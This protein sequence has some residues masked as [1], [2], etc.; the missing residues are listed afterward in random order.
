MGT[1]KINFLILFVTLLIFNLQ[2][3]SALV[4]SSDSYS[5]NL[6]GEGLT[7]AYNVSSPTYEAQTVSLPSSG[8]RGTESLNYTVNIGYFENTSYFKSV[9]IS[10]YS[11]S[12][13][14]T[15]VGSTV[16]LSILA[17]NPQSVWAKITSP[18]GQDQILTLINNRSVNYLPSPSVVGDYEVTFY[19][20]NSMGSVA[21]I[22]DHFELTS[23]PVLETS[24]P[25]SSGGPST[26]IEKCNY[27]W[28][29]TSWGLCSEGKQKRQCKNMGT[30]DGNESKP[31][32]EMNCSQALF[33][34]SV[35]LNKL[36]VSNNENLTFNINLT[37]KMGAGKFDVLIKYSIINGSN[38][39]I[40]SQV[41]TKAI[42]RSLNYEKALSDLN[43]KCGDYDF[44]IEVLYGNLQRATAGQNFEIVDGCVLSSSDSSSPKLMTGEKLMS[45]LPNILVVGIALLL[46]WIFLFVFLMNPHRNNYRI[47]L[48]SRIKKFIQSEYCRLK[49]KNSK[50]SIK[51]NKHFKEIFVSEIIK[52]KVFSSEGIEL[53]KVKEIYFDNK[54]HRIEGLLIKINSKLI[55]KIK[56]KR[57]M[58]KYN[59]ISS[60]KEIIL[61]RSEAINLDSKKFK[62]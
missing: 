49:T 29:C 47:A 54:K 38:E 22:V 25:S 15:T 10:S 43:L 6:F 33:D 11:I 56:I 7:V 20:N 17:N 19:A 21:S 31:L 14:V 48:W 2:F 41:E 18:N 24:S 23:I 40:F 8:A 55:K 51:P 46:L 57:I 32:E 5:T 37:E 44:R 59:L 28:D 58:V 45:V 26:T 13:R 30:C 50:N 1:N 12:P 39:E 9:S 60:I 35:K 61:L 36:V 3:Y 34:I 27:N 62:K 42:E 52:K 16:S 4:A 53:G